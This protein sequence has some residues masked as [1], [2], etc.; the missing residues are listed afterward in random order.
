MLAD[1]WGDSQ[2]FQ[3]SPMIWLLTNLFVYWMWSPDQWYTSRGKK[4]WLLF[5]MSF[6]LC[7]KNPTYAVHHISP[8]KVFLVTSALFGF[9]LWSVCVFIYSFKHHPSF[10]L[11]WF[12]LYEKSF[13]SHLFA[14]ENW[15]FFT[16]WL[17]YLWILDVRKWRRYILFCLCFKTFNCTKMA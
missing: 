2:T 6:T 14:Y 1:G 3:F 15:N 11:K 7:E 10:F 5:W 16:H 13:W 17:L 12:K 9:I 8:Y 4:G